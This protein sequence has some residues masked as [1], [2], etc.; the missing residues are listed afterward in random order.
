MS[1]EDTGR[2]SLAAD[3]QVR[4]DLRPDQYTL[5]WW[6]RRFE[7]VT[8]GYRGATHSI[9]IAVA[10]IAKL[11]ETNE[12]LER[13]LAEAKVTIGSLQAALTELIARVERQ[14]AWINSQVERVAKP[15]SG[16]QS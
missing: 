3:L 5:A 11:T 9:N 10:E 16:K 7:E 15:S 1:H 6:E 13:E 14:G 12:A 8:K 2:K 4:L